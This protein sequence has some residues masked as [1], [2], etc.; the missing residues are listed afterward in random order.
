MKRNTIYRIEKIQAGAYG[1]GS[2]DLGLV[3]NNQNHPKN[4][5]G[6]LK[7][8]FGIYVQKSN[9]DIWKLNGN[10]NSV[11]MA[12]KITFYFERLKYRLIEIKKI[13]FRSKC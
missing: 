13:L 4:N 7:K 9:G 6:L 1:F 8:D 12:E 2:G 11:S 5:H 3:L 10:F